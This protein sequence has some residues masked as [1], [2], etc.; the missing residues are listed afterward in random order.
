M[1]RVCT[2]NLAGARVPKI[3]RGVLKTRFCLLSC[4][5]IVVVDILFR[6]VAATSPRVFNFF[7]VQSS[8]YYDALMFTIN[9]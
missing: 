3:R 4:F 2:E 1:R 9:L 6:T 8:Y 5:G 7:F